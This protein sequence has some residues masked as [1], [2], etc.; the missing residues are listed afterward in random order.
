MSLF[1]RLTADQRDALKTARL[2]MRA[3][4]KDARRELREKQKEAAATRGA[5]LFTAGA[6]GRRAQQ[7]AD[8]RARQLH[9]RAATLIVRN[10]RETR[11]AI[12]SGN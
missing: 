11:R 10:Y 6:G 9:Q 5:L 3:A 1:T 7:R 2:D 8:A 12:R 4:L